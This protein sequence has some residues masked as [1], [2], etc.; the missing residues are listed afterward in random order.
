MDGSRA[1]SA[2]RKTHGAEAPC[3]VVMADGSAVH[4]PPEVT[5]QAYVMDNGWLRI[6]V[7][8]GEG[9]EYAETYV[10]KASRIVDIARRGA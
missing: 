10:L 8:D 3:S 1:I 5:V 4:I 9:P 6:N 7:Y 2:L